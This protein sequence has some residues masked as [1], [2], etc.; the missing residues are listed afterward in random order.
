MYR[1][2]LQK[3]AR[4]R[5][6]EAKALAAAGLH[7]GAYYLAGY[8]VECALKACIAKATLRHEFPDKARAIASHTHDLSA[9]VKLAQLEGARRVL[10]RTDGEFDRNWGIVEEW[11]EQSRYQSLG[12]EQARDLIRAIADPRHGV[13]PWVARFW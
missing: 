4:V 12:P 2:D 9:L 8:A 1:T 3:L 6:R 7:D 13:L 5:L 11:S 10:V